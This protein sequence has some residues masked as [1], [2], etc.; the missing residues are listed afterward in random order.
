MMTP[1]LRWWLRCACAAPPALHHT[2]CF[3]CV[4]VKT[5]LRY[6]LVKLVPVFQAWSGSANATY[7]QNLPRIKIPRLEPS[8][9]GAVERMR[10]APLDGPHAPP[11]RWHGVDLMLADRLNREHV[12]ALYILQQCQEALSGG[13]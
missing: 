10:P 13:F 7:I 12:L 8:V 1:H 9:Q 2:Q 6:Q 3:L 11:K 5:A 4:G